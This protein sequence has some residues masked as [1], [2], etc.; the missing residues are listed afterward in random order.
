[1]R[2][3]S[4]AWGHERLLNDW[5]TGFTTFGK[6]HFSW[7]LWSWW[8]RKEEDFTEGVS[9]WIPCKQILRRRFK[10]EWF[11]WE[12]QEHQGENEGWRVEGRKGRPIK[13]ALLIQLLDWSLIL[14]ENSRSCKEQAS[15]LFYPS[16]GYRWE[17]SKGKKK[18]WNGQII[19]FLNIFQIISRHKK[20]WLPSVIKL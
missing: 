14:W 16:K 13:D 1:M 20:M 18:N 2:V 10:D 6:F 17:V 19:S 5:F 11:I 12:I 3:K 9:V 4:F 8:L 15:E 7:T